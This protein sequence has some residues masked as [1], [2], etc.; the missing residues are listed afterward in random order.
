MKTNMDFKVFL[1]KFLLKFLINNAVTVL[2]R[3]FELLYL[4]S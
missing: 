4:E 2:K 1:I 3:V